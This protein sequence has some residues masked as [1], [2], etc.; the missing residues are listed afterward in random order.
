[1]DCKECTED[2]LR[3]LSDPSQHVWNLRSQCHH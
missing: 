2:E 3:V 1:M